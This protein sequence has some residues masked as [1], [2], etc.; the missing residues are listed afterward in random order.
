MTR[1]NFLCSERHY[2][3]HML[4]VYLALPEKFRGEFHIGKTLADPAALT[5][6]A[7]WGDYLKTTGPVIFFE[8]GAGFSY[9][10]T[11][12]HPSY[13]GG[14][15]RERVVLFCNVNEYVA[16]PNSEA[17]PDIPGVIVGSPKLDALSERPWSM[18]C[19]PTVGFSFHWD[20]QV[21][22]E[23][24][25]AFPHYRQYFS[26]VR[27]ESGRPGNAWTPVGHGHPQAWPQLRKQWSKSGMREVMHF[28]DL[29]N[30]ADVYV[31]DTSST[32]YEWAALNRPVVVLNAPWYRRE[33]KHGLRFWGNIPGI[34]V[35][36]PD[37]LEAAIRQA[38]FDDSWGPERER[39]TSIVYPH[40][41]SS[42]KRA[43]EAI[44]QLL[45]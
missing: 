40:I 22:P 9:H 10:A 19:K 28:N 26:K 5:V 25:S 33:V 31:C 30:I 7:S 4:P 15:G 36:G 39:V 27:V 38:C 23:T 45:S 20:C 37:Q 16:G 3:D 18:P 34:Q 12:S 29:V 8:H 17:Y 1:V 43:A 44:V 32:I 35:D 21:A 6:V 11:R 13:A 2:V 14:P 24:R 42:A 41:G